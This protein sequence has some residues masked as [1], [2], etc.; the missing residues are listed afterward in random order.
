MVR[1]KDCRFWEVGGAMVDAFGHC[2]CEKFIEYDGSDA[3]PR[4]ALIYWDSE[5][6]SA[7][8]ETG[9]DFGCVHARARLSDE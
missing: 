5:G 6:Y 3:F 9:P 8:F 4:D 2:S 7:G 1:C